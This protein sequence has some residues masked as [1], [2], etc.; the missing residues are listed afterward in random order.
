MTT[1][2]ITTITTATLTLATLTERLRGHGVPTC[3]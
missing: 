3:P 2:M 1:I